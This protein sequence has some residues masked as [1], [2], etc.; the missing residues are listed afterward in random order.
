MKPQGD[1]KQ[2]APKRHL[3]SS[4]MWEL[5]REPRPRRRWGARLNLEIIVGGFVV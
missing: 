4:V 2:N 3:N 5:L 1:S